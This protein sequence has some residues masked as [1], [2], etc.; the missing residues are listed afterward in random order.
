MQACFGPFGASRKKILDTGSEYIE[1]VLGEAR[2]RGRGCG[3]ILA[4]SQSTGFSIHGMPKVAM[5][6]AAADELAGEAFWL[7]QFLL[8]TTW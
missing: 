5:V 3:L 2:S 7:R 6:V 4:T 1:Q 8:Q